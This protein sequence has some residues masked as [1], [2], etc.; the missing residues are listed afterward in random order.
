VSPLAVSAARSRSGGN[1]PRSPHR[2]R[3]QIGYAGST[4]RHGQPRIHPPHL[5]SAAASIR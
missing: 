3:G 2:G 5:Q 4:G 1:T